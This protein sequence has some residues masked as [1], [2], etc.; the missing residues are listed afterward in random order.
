MH[1]DESHEAWL[2]S[3]IVELKRD[4][5][6]EKQKKEWIDVKNKQLEVEVAEMRSKISVLSKQVDNL[7]R[8][9]ELVESLQEKVAKLEDQ[10]SQPQFPVVMDGARLKKRIDLVNSKVTNIEDESLELN[11]AVGDVENKI[12]L[13]ESI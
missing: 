11:K 13:G 10:L 8:K 5:V 9:Y 12:L 6:T 1:D 2:V 3:K 7:S 4:L